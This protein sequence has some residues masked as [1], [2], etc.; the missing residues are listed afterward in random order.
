MTYNDTTNL[1]GLVQYMEKLTS[2]GYGTISGD[3]TLLKEFTTYANDVVSDIW[4]IIFSAT[5][6]WRWD[7]SNQSDLPQGVT[8]LVS[9]TYRYALPSTALTVERVEIK[10][11]NGNWIRLNPITKEKGVAALGE[12]ETQ[13][14]T[15]RG[16]F[17]TG[18]TIEIL[19]VPN[20]S[21]T[22]GL[23]VFFTRD[24]VDFVYNDTTK[25][26]GFASPFHTAVAIGSAII[27][28]QI[29]QPN[30]LTLPNLI[31][32]YDKQTTQLEEFYSERFKDNNPVVITAKKVNF[33]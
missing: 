32:N 22:G 31:K 9:G 12:L 30:S 8:N 1:Q 26:P 15:P 19:P 18:D 6:T 29:N 20:Y 7:D 11:A 13:N 5:G 27:W 3:A 10:D 17:L 16:Y 14:G 33:E 25:T 2:L 21:S 24:A 23:K 4:A 28:L